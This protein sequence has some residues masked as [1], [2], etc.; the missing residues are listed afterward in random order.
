VAKKFKHRHTASSQLFWEKMHDTLSKEGK[1]IH[2]C[3]NGVFTGRLRGNAVYVFLL[4]TFWFI[5]FYR[6]KR[7]IFHRRNKYLILLNAFVKFRRMI[8]DFIFLL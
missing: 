6:A 4:F 1:K 2:Y 5:F 3:V 7:F 8:I